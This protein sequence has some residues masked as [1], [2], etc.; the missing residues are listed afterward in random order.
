MPTASDD[1]WDLKRNLY[2]LEQ[3]QDIARHDWGNKAVQARIQSYMDGK[4]FPSLWD[5][6]EY[7][8]YFERTF[9]DDYAAQQAYL[10][11]ALS[12]SK[13]S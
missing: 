1:R 11:D 3:N 8:F 5:P 2:C 12:T 10:R 6:A 13:I 9:G 4:G 7:S